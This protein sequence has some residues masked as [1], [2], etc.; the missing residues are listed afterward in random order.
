MDTIQRLDY[1]KYFSAIKGVELVKPCVYRG[2]MFV[3]INGQSHSGKPK[4]VILGHYHYTKESTTCYAIL[5][6]KEKV[7]YSSTPIKNPLKMTEEEL[8]KVWV[9]LTNNLAKKPILKG[10]TF[11]RRYK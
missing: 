10:A 4:T 3:W 5:V 7:R 8:I 1:S 9:N 2:E 6:D 11:I